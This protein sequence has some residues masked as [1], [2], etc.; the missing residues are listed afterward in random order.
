MFALISTFV[1]IGF[2]YIS[3]QIYKGVYDLYLAMFLGTLSGLFIKYILDKKYIF[4]HKPKN[5][6]DDG[7]KFILYSLMGVFTTFIFWG[8]E[9]SFNY[10]FKS[11]NA[12]Y[13][14]VIVGLGIGYTLKY[15]LDK[16]YVFR[17]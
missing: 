16:K 3:L 17:Y 5:K 11:E 14:G 1:N 13:A 6:K 7:V 2:Q 4:Y 9:I 15:F 10:L 8:S 12:K